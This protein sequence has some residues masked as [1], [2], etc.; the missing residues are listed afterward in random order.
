MRL[1]FPDYT[2]LVLADLDRK[3]RSGG[4]P[5]SLLQPTP[6]GIRRE[7]AIV[8]KERFDRKD[9][10]VLRNFFG[11]AESG[12]QLLTLIEA[13]PIDKFRP[14]VNYLKGGTENTD[15]KNLELLAWLIDFRHRPYGFGKEVLLNAEELRALGGEDAAAKKDGPDIG[16]LIPEADECGLTGSRDGNDMPGQEELLQFDGVE[17]E[18]ESDTAMRPG[19]KDTVDLSDTAERHTKKE[20]VLL[21]DTTESD[22]VKGNVELAGM[23]GNECDRSSRRSRIK[24]LIIACLITA[25]CTSGIVAHWMS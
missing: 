4:H 21:S 16:Q 10:L 14:L 11:S 25:I 1:D 2:K 15:T 20:T 6:G 3:R 17:E 8:Y 24:N 23:Q 19:E 12:K 18:R 22:G 5:P 9:E 13:F 7:C